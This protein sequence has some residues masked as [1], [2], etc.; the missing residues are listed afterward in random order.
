[1]DRKKILDL[2]LSAAHDINNERILEEQFEVAEN[3]LLFGVGAKL[4][5]LSLVSLIVD[6]ESMVSEL[7]GRDVSLTDDRAMSQAV[8]PF[9]SI[10]TLTDYISLLLQESK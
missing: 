1:M 7:I 5:S 9:T 4:D 8:S 10:A 6:V 2:V 3:T